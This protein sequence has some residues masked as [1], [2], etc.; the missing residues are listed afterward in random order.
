MKTF[1]LVAAAFG[2]FAAPAMAQP[3]TTSRTGGTIKS[4][5]IVSQSQPGTSKPSSTQPKSNITLGYGKIEW[6]YTPQKP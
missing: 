1:V 4:A 6:T 5:S 3:N 2:I